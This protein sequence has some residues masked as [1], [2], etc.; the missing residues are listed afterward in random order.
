MGVACPRKGEQ[1][2]KRPKRWGGRVNCL[3]NLKKML[4]RLEDGVSEWKPPRQI[5]TQV[6]VML[7]PGEQGEGTLSSV[8]CEVTT[9]F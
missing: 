2:V 7:S 5:S 3:R 8:K 9:G 1:Q 4:V 6:A